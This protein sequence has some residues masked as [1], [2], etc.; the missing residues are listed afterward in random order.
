MFERQVIGW[1]L[2]ST[3]FTKEK[4]IPA[5]IMAVL[6][7]RI[8]K[9]LIFDSDRDVQYASKEFRKLLS[10]NCLIIQSMSRKVNY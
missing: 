7:R 4:I 6:K 2:S 5:W 10:K 3:L 8:D 1:T 9:P